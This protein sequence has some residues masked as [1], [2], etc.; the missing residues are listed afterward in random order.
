MDFNQRSHFG[1]VFCQESQLIIGKDGNVEV[2][3]QGVANKGYCGACVKG[4]VYRVRVVV[5]G[6]DLAWYMG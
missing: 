3:D 6:E 1:F 2:G 4:D 5:E